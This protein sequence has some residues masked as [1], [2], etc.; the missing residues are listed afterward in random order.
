MNTVLV[1]L[2][3]VAVFAAIV[4]GGLEALGIKIPALTQ[5]WQR[6][7]LAIAGLGVVGL[8][9][10]PTG[11]PPPNAPG[12]S[13]TSS[14][15]SLALPTGSSSVATSSASS[16]SASLTT[17]S[18]GAQSTLA[19][20]AASLTPTSPQGTNVPIR[21][22]RPKGPVDLYTTFTGTGTIPK[23]YVLRIASRTSDGSHY[24]LAGSAG[25]NPATGR[26]SIPCVQIGDTSDSATG[27]TFH[28]YALLVTTAQNGD[29]NTEA[30]EPG[31]ILNPPTAWIKDSMDVVRSPNHNAC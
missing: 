14:G 7:V 17:S 12:P 20:T 2:G 8:G 18:T 30:G 23:G 13:V 11:N 22:D 29:I 27:G 28:I 15:I 21:I 4:A 19:S 25:P 3:A 5:T 1:S 24:Y 6:I 9:F 26:W 16:P 31:Y 10:I